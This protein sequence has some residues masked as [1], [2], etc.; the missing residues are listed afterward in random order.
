MNASKFN[1]LIYANK[2][3]AAGVPEAQ[4]EVH[5]L[6]LA[7]VLDTQM[8]TKADLEAVN[9]GLNARIDTVAV[10]LNARIDAVEANLNARIDTVE[11]NLNA[12]IDTVEATLT[13]RIAASEARMG[14]SLAQFEARIELKFEKQFGEF[15]NDVIKWFAI[16]SVSQIGISTTIVALIVHAR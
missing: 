4:A 2:L 11:A 1:S 7:D 5:A 13:A 10:N 15:K 9:V 12:R 8:V 3:E 14:E 16:L 6:A